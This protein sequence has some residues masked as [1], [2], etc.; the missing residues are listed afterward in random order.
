MMQYAELPIPEGTMLERV[1]TGAAWSEGPLWLPARGVLRWSDIPGNRVLEFDPGTGTARVHANE[2]EFQNGRAVASDGTTIVCSHGRRAVERWD[3]HGFVET[4]VDRWNGKRL[5][6]PNDI[7]IHSDGSIWFTDPD[8][9]IRQPHEGHPGE[10]EYGGC[11]VFRFAD[12]RLDAVITDACRP[13]GIAFSPDETVLYVTDTATALG[14]GDAHCIRT[15]DLVQDPA[16]QDRPAA[17]RLAGA[18][19]LA[20]VAPGVPDGIAVDVEGRIWSSSAS[21]VQVFD[22]D[23]ARLG[24]IPVPEVVGNLCFADDGALYIAAT[25]SLYRIATATRAAATRTTPQRSG[26]QRSASPGSAR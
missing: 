3:E 22:A 24:E 7:A 17:V 20:E 19:L 13:N 6:S 10:Q 9:G 1:A 5:N 15:Y 4:I 8:Y 21:G 18:R 26:A 12:G 14:D 16:A 25:T 2:V 11:N 23:G